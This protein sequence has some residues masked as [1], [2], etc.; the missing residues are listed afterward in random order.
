[1]SHTPTHVLNTVELL[2]QGLFLQCS[3][4]AERIMRLIADLRP[5]MTTTELIR[6]GGDSDGGYLV[7][8]DLVAVASCFSPGVGLIASFEADLQSRF[9]IV[10]HLADGSVSGPPAGLNPKSFVRKFVGP[11]DDE[12]HITLG[13]WMEHQPEYTTGADLAL[14]MDIEG[15]EYAA[16]LATPRHYLKRFRWMVI[17]FHSVI[18]WCDSAYFDVVE[19]VFRKLLQDFVVVHNHPNNCC[20]LLDLGGVPAPNVFEVTFHRRDRCRDVG[21]QLNLPHP[22]DRPNFPDAPEL[23]LPLVWYCPAS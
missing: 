20:G 8:N 14:Q 15:A 11:C 17:E 18:H 6:V 22:L 1:M 10:S 12:S 3:T 16:L 5:R 19:N 21:P 2:E 7:P 4:P 23:R 9:K 13:T